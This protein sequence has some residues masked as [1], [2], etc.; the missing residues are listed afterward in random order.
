MTVQELMTSIVKLLIHNSKRV[1]EPNFSFN[2]CI[3]SIKRGH[4]KKLFLE[5]SQC[6]LFLM[7]PF[8]KREINVKMDAVRYMV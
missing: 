4:K 6:L 1:N 5:K 2:V 7:C 3:C 8:R